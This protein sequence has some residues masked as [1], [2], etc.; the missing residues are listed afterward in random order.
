MVFNLFLSRRLLKKKL[1][2][3][4]LVVTDVDGVLTNGEIGYSAELN[5]LKLFN[6]KDGLAVKLLQT[7]GI[8]LAFISG[9]DS[10][11]TQK[12][13]KTLLIDECHTNIEKKSRTLKDIQKRLSISTE[14]TLYIGDDIN[15]LDVLPY[16]SLFVVPKD[17]NSYVK[18]IAD[19]KLRTNGGKGVLREVCDMVLH[20]KE[21]N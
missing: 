12:R 21:K 10:E 8:E 13:A 19:I 3:I 20:A 7:N 2:G 18:R 6:V 4:K 1:K 17:C 15:D 9:G 14:S 5:G 11:A 16:V